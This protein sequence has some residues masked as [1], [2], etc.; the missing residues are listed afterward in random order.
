MRHIA[1][2]LAGLLHERVHY[3]RLEVRA[4][5]PSRG[6]VGAHGIAEFADLLPDRVEWLLCFEQAIAD[7][8]QILRALIHC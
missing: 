3:I 5:I 6:I 4:G 7:G 8:K 1:Q 2:R